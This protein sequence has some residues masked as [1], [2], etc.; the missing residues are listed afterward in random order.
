MPEIG[1]VIIFVVTYTYTDS[2]N[3]PTGSSVAAF[4]N[5]VTLVAGS[6]AG[7]GIAGGSGSG[8]GGGTALGGGTAG[9]SAIST[10]VSTAGSSSSIT[11]TA[12]AQS[13]QIYA[14]T[15]SSFSLNGPSFS[16]QPTSV[17]YSI[18]GS[19]IQLD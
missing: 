7:G 18:L 8:I 11:V 1:D 12:L 9:G 5:T 16:S 6:G 4:S 10:A 3:Q 13:A 17:T 19:S 2:N 15:A 14:D